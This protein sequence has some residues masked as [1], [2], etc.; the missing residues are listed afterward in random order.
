[1]LAAGLSFNIPEGRKTA[2]TGVASCF[3]FLFEIL[4]SVGAAALVELF[5]H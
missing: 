5:G 3:F 4:Y 1:M 2:Y